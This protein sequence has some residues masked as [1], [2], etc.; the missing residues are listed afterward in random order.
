MLNVFYHPL[1]TYGIDPEARFPRERYALLA[2]RLNRVGAIK[3]IEP[4]QARIDDIT[5]AH[6][7]AY[8]TRFLNGSLSEKETR[9]IGL[10][11][12]TENIVARTLYLIGGS[13]LALDHVLEHGGIAGNMAGGTHHAFRDFGSGYCVFNDLA[14]CA[15]RALENPTINRIL[16]L[17][18]D[19]HQGDGTASIL[20]NR[21]DATT[22]SAHGRKNFPFHKQQ[23]DIDIELDCGT[24]D[25]EYL[26]KVDRLL[27][28][29]K[30]EEFDLVLYQAG[31]D[32]LASDRL[33][34]LSLTREG[35]DQRNTMVFE[36]L[37]SVALPTVVFMGGGYAEPIEDTVDAFVD[38]FSKAAEFQA[39]RSFNRNDC[40][41]SN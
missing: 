15:I 40:A 38:L 29:L 34:R 36:K 2:E 21:N 8:V 20:K 5:A 7:S 10:R 37:H 27:S 31:V 9:K 35:L 22:V 33:G 6:D 11:P 18:L 17:D 24:R 41:P 12:W 25:A 14:I 26:D 32:P 19:V 1:Y 16:I 23:S 3:I 28:R 39:K 30:L 13:V 4:S